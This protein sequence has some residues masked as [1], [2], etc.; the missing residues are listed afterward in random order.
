MSAAGAI[1]AA[2]DVRR[3]DHIVA[4]GELPLVSVVIPVRNDARRLE[5]CLASLAEQDYPR[6][7][8]EIIVIDNGST[9]DSAPVAATFG[10][11]VLI[12]PGLRV[13]ALRNRG[14]EVAR[15]SL[16]AFVDSDHEAPPGWMRTA[17]EA[18]AASSEVLILG[19]PY[20][21]PPDGTWVQ[22][23]WELHRVRGPRRKR[24]TWLGTGN[25]FLRAGDFQLVGG[26]REDLV[27]AE[28]V[29]LC[30]RLAE[31]PGQILSDMRF[32][33]IHHGEPPTLMAFFWKEYWRGSSGVWG[34]ISHGMPLHELPSLV[35]PLLHLLGLA[36]VL[37]LL[38]WALVQGGTAWQ[39]L[40]AATCA[41]LMPSLLLGLKTSWEM[42]RL[43]AM[44][45]LAVLYLTYGLA[46]A[47]ALFK[48]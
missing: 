31:L 5:R 38:P 9:D 23:I 15:G 12:H 16:L 1:A 41:L 18:L 30:V 32:A 24:A 13:G 2:D 26:F 46:R 19:S 29:D 7:R 40:C 39:W 21:A 28:D 44:P 10:A 3:P 6:D 37:F 4:H 48:H 14:V 22:R 36:T 35:Y 47:A 17:C 45:A 27:A 11:R 43:S 42:R 20:L 25:M 8:Y 33:N 34:Y